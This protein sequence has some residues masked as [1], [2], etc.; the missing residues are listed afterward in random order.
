MVTSPSVTSSPT[1]TTRGASIAT[2][3]DSTGD[4]FCEPHSGAIPTQKVPPM[5]SKIERERVA[6]GGKPSG[7]IA[8]SN[9][10]FGIDDRKVCDYNEANFTQRRCQ[11]TLNE[12]ELQALINEVTH[13]NEWALGKLYDACAGRVYAL[14]LRIVGDHP[15]A[16]EV[17]SDVFLQV[18]QQADRFDHA[19]GKVL[20]WLLTLCRSR[21]L[22]QLRRR[23][24]SMLHDDPASLL[25]EVNDPSTDPARLVSMMQSGSQIQSALRE[26]T[27]TQ[28]H[29]LSLAFFQGLSH[30][31]IADITGTP[32][33]TV[34]ATLRRSMITLKSML[35]DLW[36]G[37]E[38]VA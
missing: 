13:H 9:T 20:T 14:A 3:F 10:V 15:T 19:R 32:L 11:T 17:V 36:Q 22:D 16:E 7:P 25:T 37:G 2:R 21:A 23:D 31:E 24:R 12:A 26:L 28:Q 38:D 4:S 33:G 29:L 5:E 35:S 27:A 34:K 6:N 18:W 8:L 30:Q 1:S